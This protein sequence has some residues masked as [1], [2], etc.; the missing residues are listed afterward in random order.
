MDL[1]HL[2]RIHV[3][4]RG[5]QADL[6]DEQAIAA[7]ATRAV[8]QAGLTLM[9]AAEHSY[10]PHGLTVV[11]ILA[12]SHCALSTWPELRCI[13]FDATICGGDA[14]ALQTLWT[15]LAD[16]LQP[17]SAVVSVDTDDLESPA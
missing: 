13:T 12:Q 7:A 11:L 9:A 2:D 1:S 5:C 8:G 16:H 17:D 10:V 6:L 4:A 15:S 14:A 3:V